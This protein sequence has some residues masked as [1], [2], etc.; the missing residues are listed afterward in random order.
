[1]GIKFEH[2][3]I[4]PVR[5]YRSKDILFGIGG[6]IYTHH[7]E[8]HLRLDILKNIPIEFLPPSIHSLGIRALPLVSLSK[9]HRF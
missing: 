6:I 1:M 8:C 2:G 7:Q 4:S 5:Y 3:L 9:K